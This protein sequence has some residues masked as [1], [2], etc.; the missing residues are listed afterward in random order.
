MED[1]ND[2]DFATNEELV[3]CNITKASN[4]ESVELQ[5]IA[6]ENKSDS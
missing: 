5:A 2:I 6:D 1:V 3:F 4:D